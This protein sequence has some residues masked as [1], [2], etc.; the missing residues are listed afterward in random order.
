MNAINGPGLLVD[1]G[2]RVEQA[3]LGSQ[4]LNVQKRRLAWLG[5][6]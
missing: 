2:G 3:V 6:S 1:F 4:F 5:G